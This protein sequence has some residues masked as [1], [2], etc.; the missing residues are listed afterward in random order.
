MRR[1]HS[2]ELFDIGLALAMP[3]ARQPARGVLTN[4]GGPAILATDAD[5]PGLE[6]APLSARR[7][8]LRKILVPGLPSTIRSTWSRVRRP[9]TRSALKLLCAMRRSTW[10]RR[11]GARDH[12]RSGGDRA[13]GLGPS[14][15]AQASGWPLHVARRGLRDRERARQDCAGVLTESA[16]RALVA[17]DEQHLARADGKV[18]RARRSRGRKRWLAGRLGVEARRCLS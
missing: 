14:R 1:V 8:G 2:V 3:A 9:T 12:A 13:R 10:C 4:A 16:V 18:Q 5:P 6:M 7:A 15:R 17:L 11:S